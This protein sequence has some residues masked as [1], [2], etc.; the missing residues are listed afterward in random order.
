LTT[1]AAGASRTSAS[2]T[3]S[4]REAPALHRPQAV[5]ATSRVRSMVGA[6]T[7][8]ALEARANRWATPNNPCPAPP[9]PS[10]TH[11]TYTTTV[12]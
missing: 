6:K 2:S 4:D 7:C 11:T 12:A 8:Q 1:F 10:H 9:L 3:I 5:A